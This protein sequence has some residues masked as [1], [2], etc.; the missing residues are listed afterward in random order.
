MPSPLVFAIG[1]SLSRKTPAP[2]WNSFCRPIRRYPKTAFKKPGMMQF[3]A[4]AVFVSF[5]TVAVVVFAAA[6]VTVVAIKFAPNV[7]STLKDF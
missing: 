2:S 4:D 3:V 1:A 6:A 7:I 5:A